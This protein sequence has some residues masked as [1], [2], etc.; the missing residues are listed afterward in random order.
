MWQKKIVY[1][2]TLNEPNPCFY[3]SKSETTSAFKSLVAFFV[4]RDISDLEMQI[5]YFS[6]T[7]RA[8]GTKYAND[9]HTLI[10]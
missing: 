1:V 5:W 3:C 8:Q 7:R 9:T 10:L 2:V 6:S 4:K